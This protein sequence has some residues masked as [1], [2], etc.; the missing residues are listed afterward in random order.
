MKSGAPCPSPKAK[1]VHIRQYKGTECLLL[2]TLLQASTIG[3]PAFW[4]S[5]PFY[6]V[7][8]RIWLVPGISRLLLGAHEVTGIGVACCHYG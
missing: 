4:L 6:L 3:F 2:C 1:Q 5:F 8:P 7:M